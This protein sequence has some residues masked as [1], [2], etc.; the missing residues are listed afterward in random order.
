MEGVHTDFRVTMQPAG[1]PFDEEVE[2][3]PVATAGWKNGYPWDRDAA[4]ES[5]PLAR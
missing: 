5:S 3:P 4:L 2:A 1:K